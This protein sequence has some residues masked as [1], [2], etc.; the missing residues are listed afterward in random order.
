MPLTHLPREAQVHFGH[1]LVK[2]NGVLRKLCFFAMTLPYSDAFFLRADK[3]A[4]HR[5][6]L[7]RPCAT[8]SARHENSML[9]CPKGFTHFCRR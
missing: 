6:L 4:M 8:R 9:F 3:R 5:D 2:I 7:E 1:A